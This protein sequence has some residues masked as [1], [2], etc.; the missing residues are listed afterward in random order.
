MIESTVG[1]KLVRSERS[2]F[3]LFLARVLKE[4][5]LYLFVQGLRAAM[6]HPGR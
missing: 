2:Q 4:T 6:N 5:P 3:D 1:E